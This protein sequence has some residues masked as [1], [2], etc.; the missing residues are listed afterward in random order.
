MNSV[1]DYDSVSSANSFSDDDNDN[2]VG[3]RCRHS[4]SIHHIVNANIGDANTSTV[5]DEALV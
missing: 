2:D 3:A 4:Y 1:D 5:D